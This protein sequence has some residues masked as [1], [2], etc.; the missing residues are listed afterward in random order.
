[1]KPY[2]LFTLIF[3]NAQPFHEILFVL[4]GHRLGRG[5]RFIDNQHDPGS[6]KA[7]MVRVG[8][9]HL[10]GPSVHSPAKKCH[11]PLSLAGLTPPSQPRKNIAGIPARPNNRSL[12]PIDISE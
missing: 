1:L 7:S 4:P 12:D 10:S 9:V 6:N 2:L 3:K 5:G 11:P 8:R